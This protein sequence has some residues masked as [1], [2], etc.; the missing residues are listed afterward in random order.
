MNKLSECLEE[1]GILTSVKDDALE[2]KV[3]NVFQKIVIEIGQHDIQAC[4][5]G[6]KNNQAIVKFSNIQERLPSDIKSEKKQLEN[7]D[8]ALFN[9]PDGMKIFSLTKHQFHK[10]VNLIGHFRMFKITL[11]FVFS[12]PS[13]LNLKLFFTYLMPF[14]PKT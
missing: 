7:L 14:S 8:S 1:L 11:D 12:C 6:E 13:Y 2:D 3:L 4:H 9:F 5:K 10:I